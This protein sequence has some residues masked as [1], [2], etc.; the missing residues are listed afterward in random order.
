MAELSAVLQQLKQERARVTAQL[1]QLTQAI[2]AL[3]K[4]AGSGG[5]VRVKRRLSLAARKK[6][7]AAQ[8]ARWERVRA[9]AAKKAA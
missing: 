8:R 6:I 3:G 4:A 7:A 5:G 1:Q 2:Q 9:K